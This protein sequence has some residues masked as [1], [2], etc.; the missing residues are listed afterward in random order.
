MSFSRGFWLLFLVYCI[1]SLVTGRGKTYGGKVLLFIDDL[2]CALL[3]RNTGISISGM[4]GA[5]MRLPNPPQWAVKLS[6]MLSKVN[7]PNHCEEARLGD[8]ERMKE[9]I[10]ILEGKSPP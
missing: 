2:L 10:E 4:T 1:V 9:S 6:R 8:I 5:Y 7:P 3:W